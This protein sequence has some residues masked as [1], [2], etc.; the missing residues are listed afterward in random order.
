VLARLFATSEPPLIISG[1][2]QGTALAIRQVTNLP[3]PVHEAL[4][5]T[6]RFDV[7]DIRRAGQLVAAYDRA[8]PA[9]G[10]W[11]FT[12]VVSL[13]AATRAVLEMVDRI[14]Q[15]A[16]CLEG[17]TVPPVRSGA[18]KNF[19]DRVALFVDPGNRALF[20]R[21][22]ALRGEIEHLHENRYLETF[23]RPVRLGLLKDAGHLEY[24]VR[25]CL[26]RVLDTPALWPHFC[27]TTALERFWALPE[28]QRRRLWG[29]CIDPTQA[30]CP[31]STKIGSGTSI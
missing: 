1:A 14:H 17:L 13:Y 27:T 22:Y 24:V 5:M 18:G 7:V 28:A 10:C 23:D 9:S 15:Y 16:R 2:H 26:A 11:R 29:P 4:D 31:A 25:R 30:L 8:R 3:R 21:L 20:E 6:R 19:A 12:R